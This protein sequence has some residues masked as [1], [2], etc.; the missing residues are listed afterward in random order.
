MRR[1]LNIPSVVYL[2]IIMGFIY[3][4]VALLIVLSFNS[5][6]S[7]FKWNGASLVWYREMVHDAAVAH[8]VR[9]TFSIGLIASAIA[10]MIGTLGCIGML[11]VS[12]KTRTAIDALNNISLLNADIVTG[13]SLMLFFI[14]I[15]LYLNWGT[16]LAAH[17][18]I[19][20]PYVILSVWPRL[21]QMGRLH[22]E[23]ALDLGATPEYAFRKVIIP[24]IMPGI[25]AGF[26]MSFTISIDDFVITHFTRGAGVDT[27]S[28]LIY[29][30][31]KVGIRPS[32]IAISTV[33]FIAGIVILG[34]ADKLSS[35]KLSLGSIIG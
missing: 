34:L 7:M 11:F 35:R 27:I 5:G 20:L 18:T 6:K 21:R 33:I 12:K 15:G 8:A 13:I 2:I 24:E 10:T 25:S 17:V 1:K 26:M 31:A 23:A 9:N 19:C 14:A 29:S 22:Y 16:V 28:T 3:L 4:P 32:L 30:Q